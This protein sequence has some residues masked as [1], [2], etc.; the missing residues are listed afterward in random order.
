MKL[1]VMV[2]L[3][4]FISWSCKKKTESVYL[5]QD[6]IRIVQPRLE[7]TNQL[8]DSIA[9]LTARLK[10]E[11]SKIYYTTN[12]DDPT[13][14]TTEY[15]A[16]LKVL[17]PGTYKFRA[18]HPDWKESDIAE[19]KFYKRGIPIDTII[20]NTNPNKRYQGVGSLTLH[21]N[22]KGALDFMND[23]W[24][25]F[26]TIADATVHLKHA[27]FV[28]SIHIGYLCDPGSWI[29]PPEGIMIKTS[30]DGTKFTHKNV[31][32]QPLDSMLP[33]TLKNVEITIGDTIKHIHVTVKNVA[34]IPDWHEGKDN[35]AW[36][37]MD[38]WV[39]NNNGI[40]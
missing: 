5:Q 13:E 15:K 12:G 40:R 3:L 10:L 19:I 26:D 16:P 11:G 22:K 28:K 30:A 35:K 27:V 23:Q 37:F 17:S 33:P 29:F 7:A 39:L 2:S 32:L 34:S 8:I 14:N 31:N 38:E 21:N 20:W 25:G 6:Q 9:Y 24:L 18:Y 1:I 4:V 36:L